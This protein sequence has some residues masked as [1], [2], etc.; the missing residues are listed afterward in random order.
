MKKEILRRIE[1]L[2]EWRFPAHTNYPVEGRGRHAM[3]N[4][5]ILIGATLRAGGAAREELD[6]AGASLNPERRAKLTKALDAARFFCAARRR[7]MNTGGRRP[8]PTA[9]SPP[10]GPMSAMKRWPSGNRLAGCAV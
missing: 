3:T 6:A 2:E 8:R 1:A 4:L 7:A 5:A 9:T 10:R